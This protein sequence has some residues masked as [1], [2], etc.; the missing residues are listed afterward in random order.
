MDLLNHWGRHTTQY[1]DHVKAM[2]DKAYDSV[3]GKGAEA[4]R[5]ALDS[6][7]AQIEKVGVVD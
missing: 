4:A 5:K 1:H 2:L 7:Y 6:I 3:K